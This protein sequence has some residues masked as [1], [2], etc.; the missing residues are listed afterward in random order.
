MKP[1]RP[2]LRLPN[3]RS[4]HAN[5]IR[6]AT[7]VGITSGAGRIPVVLLHGFPELAFSWRHQ[8]TA[9]QAAGFDVIAPDLRGYGDTGP[10]GDVAD[11]R[12]ANLARDVTGLLDALGIDRAVIV[13]HDFGGALG[14]TLARDHRSRVLGVASLNTPYTRRTASNLVDTVLRARGPTH[15]MVKFQE[16]GWAEA[17]L[18]ADVRRTFQ[19]LMRR[20]KMPLAEFRQLLPRLQALPATLFIGEPDAMG[21]PLLT[22]EELDVFV[23]AYEVTGFTGALNWYR[24]LARNWMDTADTPDRVLVPALMISAA[25][26]FLLPPETT[27]GME[28]IVP[29]LE[30]H[31]IVGNGHWTQQE[32]PEEVNRLLIDWLRRKIVPLWP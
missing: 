19:G 28:D 29:M 21:E 6:I 17:L 13:G 5:G 30:R 18:G 3:W 23:E 10:Q 26:D 16:P 8:V 9:I 1:D 27:R 31:L 12:M 25:D 32:R 20:P 7:S 22:T 11:Y 15:Y 14:W 4:V 24:N 2:R